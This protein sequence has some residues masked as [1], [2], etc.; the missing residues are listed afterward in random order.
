MIIYPIF[1]P[2][3]GCPTKCVYCNQNLITRTEKIDI[4]HQSIKNF[5]RKHHHES[6]EIAFFG[7]TFTN[8]PSAKQA[9][10]LDEVN[11]L[12]DAETGIRISTKP[13]CISL[14]NLTFLKSKNVKTIE[15]GIQSFDDEVLRS[16]KRGYSSQTAVKSCEMIKENGF[17]LGIQLMPGLPESNRESDLNS[18][19][20]TIELKPAYTRLY[21]T[22]VLKNTE[23]EQRF[24]KGDYSPLELEQTIDFLVKA[25]NMLE[26]NDITVIKTGLHSDIDEENVIAGPYH[27]TLGELVKAKILLKKIIADFQRERTLVYSKKDTSL[28]K[29]FDRKMIKRMK[30][31]LKV[32]KIRAKADADM[33]KG[34]CKFSDTDYGEIW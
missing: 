27:Q 11:Q 21:P 8:L 24:K 18:I 1:I 13:D 5:C 22:I 17:K 12:I 31:L 10:L 28:F 14:D 9:E 6:K 16:S 25:I 2:F 34:E 4:D 7:G 3:W 15:L 23:L 32:D 30:Q 19:K 33:A 29:G 26:A 20:K